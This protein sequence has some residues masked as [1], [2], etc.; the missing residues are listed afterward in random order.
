MYDVAVACLYLNLYSICCWFGVNVSDDVDNGSN[1]GDGGGGQHTLGVKWTREKRR[2]NAHT[3]YA[4]VRM[5]RKFIG[6]SG[7]TVAGTST[8]PTRQNATVQV[9]RSLMVTRSSF[10]LIN[11]L[12][13]TAHTHKYKH[14]ETQ[15]PTPSAIAAEGKCSR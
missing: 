8:H 12:E 5:K 3:S 6:K 13:I 14:R 1:S 7:T 9:S 10:I 4:N 2:G 11:H 15:V